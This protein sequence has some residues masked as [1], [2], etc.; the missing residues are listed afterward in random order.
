MLKNLNLGWVRSQHLGGRGRWIFVN[1]RPVWFTC[2]WS[3]WLHSEVLS[4]KKKLN[5]LKNH[6]MWSHISCYPFCRKVVSTHALEGGRRK[7]MDRWLI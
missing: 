1:S 3:S 2:V 5:L 7:G 4:Q 6:K